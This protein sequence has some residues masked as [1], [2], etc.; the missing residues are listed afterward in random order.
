MKLW[1]EIYQLALAICP[2]LNE[3]EQGVLMR[4]CAAAERVLKSRLRSGLSPQD[5]GDCF[6]CAAAWMA[7]DSLQAG[8][9]VEDIAS[10]TAG[11]VSVNR[12]NRASGSLYQRAMDL[13]APYLSSGS[14]FLGVRG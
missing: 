3:Q 6:C 10:F 14:A 2:D 11:N 12:T 5:C 13:M 1:N 7:V 4:L 9:G 8:S